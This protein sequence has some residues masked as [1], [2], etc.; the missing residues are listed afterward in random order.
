MTWTPGIL[1]LGA[2]LR[3]TGWPMTNCSKNQIDLRERNDLG[4]CFLFISYSRQSNL[5]STLPVRV[6][7]L[8][9]NNDGN[10][11]HSRFKRIFQ[12]SSTNNESFRKKITFTKSINSDLKYLA[13]QLNL[14][15]WLRNQFKSWRCITLL[16]GSWFLVGISSKIYIISSLSPWLGCPL[17]LCLTKKNFKN[18]LH[19]LDIRS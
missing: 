12:N 1:V 16:F 17:L 2:E 8:Y 14:V 15:I 19:T 3:Y 9:L 18:I 5:F 6:I 13:F 7:N 10:L 4:N 11:Q